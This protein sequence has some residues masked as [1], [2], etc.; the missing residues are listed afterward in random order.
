MHDAVTGLPNQRAFQDRLDETLANRQSGALLLLHLDRFRGVIETFGHGAGEQV[1]RAVGERLA[2]LITTDPRLCCVH[3]FESEL[4]AILLNDDRADAEAPRLAARIA[5]VMQVP[6]A[7]DGRSLFFTFSIGAAVFPVD[8][9]DRARLLRRADTALHQVLRSGGSGF[10][11]YDAEMDR[12]AL[13]RLETEHAL[14]H[15]EQR[16]ELEL[17]YQPQV[18]IDSGRIVG[19]EALV[20]WRYPGKGLVSPAE[21]IPLAEETGMIGPMGQWILATACA[22]NRAWQDAGLA[23]VVVAV[24]I[25]PRQFADPG[26]P[27]LLRRVLDE[28]GLAPEW[29][30]LEI[31][32]GAA[33]QDLAQAEAALAEFKAIGV[34]LSI[35]DFGTGHSSLAYL[36][37]FPIDKLK[38]DQSFVRNLDR[39][40]SDAAIARSVV[41][42]GHGL[43]L[44]V[45]AE[46]VE[47]VAQLDRLR[48]FGCQEIQGY[49]FS[50]PVGADTVA[51]LLAAPPWLAEGAMP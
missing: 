25:S 22:H 28:T 39:D 24:N 5:G 50:K 30:E 16:G 43:G 17:H 37:R 47:T 11:R 29:L 31:T 1:L 20:R 27:G 10:R 49:L 41:A 34:S 46:G 3:R 13:A 51:A 21:F 36:S 23:P 33:M 15:A 8:G 9:A 42:L 48:G 38:V 32:E 12:C 44:T 7:L 26:L 14:R 35:D 19:L 6:L 2:G 4:F 18:A 45:I 40:E